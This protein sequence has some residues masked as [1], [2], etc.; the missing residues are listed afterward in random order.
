MCFQN[1]YVDT[2]MYCHVLVG[3]TDDTLS[4]QDLISELTTTPSGQAAR[5]GWD[6]QGPAPTACFL[7]LGGGPL[8]KGLLPRRQ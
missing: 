2:R 5:P 8:V 7:G 1:T 4:V 6:L 3:W